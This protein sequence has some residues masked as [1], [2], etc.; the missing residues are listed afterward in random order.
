MV[1]H[2]VKCSLDSCFPKSKNLS[3]LISL[4]I[5][6]EEI[7]AQAETVVKAIVITTAQMIRIIRITAV[8]MIKGKSSDNAGKS[9][10]SGNGKND[11]NGRSSDKEKGNKRKNKEHHGKGKGLGKEKRG[12]K[13]R[14]LE[15]IP[16]LANANTINLPEYLIEPTGEA[17]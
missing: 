12:G 9:S 7:T 3:P 8:H 6:V 10:G 2:G 5:K 17:A 15:Q 13:W 1:I 4:M 14:N 11:N 16:L